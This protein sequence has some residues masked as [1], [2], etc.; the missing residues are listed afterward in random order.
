MDF[1]EWKPH[2]VVYIRSLIM[3]CGY[4]TGV[5]IS[6]KRKMCF[7]FISFSFCLT[8]SGVACF[9]VV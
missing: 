3:L 2:A 6:V 7:N 4:K 9:V 8:L 5:V 1:Y